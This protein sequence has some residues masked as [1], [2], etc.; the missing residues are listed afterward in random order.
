MLVSFSWTASSGQTLQLGSDTVHCYNKSEL[1]AIATRVIQATECDTIVSML[2]MEVTLRDSIIE[3]SD[4]I[5]IT[6]TKEAELYKSMLEDSKEMVKDLEVNLDDEIRAHK[7]TKIKWYV[8]LG[9]TIL[10]MTLITK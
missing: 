7:R 6:K 8:S 5:A 9:L 2:E 10:V 4:G 1:Q 3:W